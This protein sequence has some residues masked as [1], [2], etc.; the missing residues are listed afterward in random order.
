[1]QTADWL[2]TTVFRVRIQWDYC[3]FVLICMV[4][5]VVRSLRSIL[6]ALPSDNGDANA[7]SFLGFSRTLLYG[8]KETTLGTRLTPIKTSLNNCRRVF[9][10]SG[11]QH[12]RLWK[13]RRF[14]SQ[15]S[16]CWVCW[17]KDE[18]SEFPN[19]NRARSASVETY[20]STVRSDVSS[21]TVC[22]VI[23]NPGFAQVSFVENLLLDLLFLIVH[24]MKLISAK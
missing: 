22:C 15:V 9:Q 1:M 2:W 23:I 17:A 6:T 10:V 3:C 5:T 19:M 24:K 11:L 20:I 16:A 7:I 18:F 21:F 12:R 14:W 8:E 4:K 13:R